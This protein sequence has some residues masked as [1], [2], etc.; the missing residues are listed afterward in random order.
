MHRLEAN[1]DGKDCIVL[2]L[3]QLRY[4]LDGGFPTL[5]LF[6][7]QPIECIDCGLRSAFVL[8][9]FRE[10]VDV[11]IE[12]LKVLVLTDA[13]RS[14]TSPALSVGRPLAAG[15]WAVALYQRTLG[16]LS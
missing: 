10:D 11:V 13:I 2:I 7:A 9:V 4:S 3:Q 15:R 1:S 5:A 8:Q 6:A 12:P 16:L 14:V